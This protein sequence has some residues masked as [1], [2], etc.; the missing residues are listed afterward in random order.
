MESEEGGVPTE[1]RK[2]SDLVVARDEG[3]EENSAY[4]LQIDSIRL[5]SP[6]MFEREA[7]AFLTRSSSFARSG[8][9]RST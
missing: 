9:R 7:R 1:R 4:H 5:V 8:P 6:S 2:R 3:S